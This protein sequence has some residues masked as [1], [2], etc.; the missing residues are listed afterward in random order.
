S[1]PA[2]TPSPTPTSTPACAPAPTARRCCERPAW[3]WW[4]RP[5]ARATCSPTPSW[6]RAGRRD[7]HPV[8]RVMVVGSGGQDGR[9]LTARLLEEGHRV[10]GI[11]RGAVRDSETGPVSPVDIRDAA[12]VSAAV[13]G[14]APDEVYYLAAHHSSSEKA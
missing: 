2:R 12:Q 8:R 14:F 6:W 10:L 7:P 13:A 1:C 3:R 9:L 11:A 4:S 5:S